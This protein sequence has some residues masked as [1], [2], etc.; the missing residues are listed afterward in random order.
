MV[1]TEELLHIIML[2][3]K[4]L[5]I[6]LILKYANSFCI[7][8]PSIYNSKQVPESGKQNELSTNKSYMGY[9]AM[10]KEARKLNRIKR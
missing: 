5:R 10:Q 3:F 2:L 6:T 7:T 8:K 4:F 9:V 1:Q